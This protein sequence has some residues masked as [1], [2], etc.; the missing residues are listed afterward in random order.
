MA[1]QSTHPSKLSRPTHPRWI[2]LAALFAFGGGFAGAVEE[3][4]SLLTI[5]VDD[6]R[7]LAALAGELEKRFPI[8]VT[9]EEGPWAAA[10]DVED[11]T[12]A[13]IESNGPG[14]PAPVI[15]I[16]G[17]RKAAVSFEYTLDPAED[18]PT[19]YADLLS[20]LVAQYN[21]SGAPGTFRFEGGDLDVDQGDLT[22]P[23]S[24]AVEAAVT[25]TAESP[26]LDEHRISTGATVTQT[27]LREDPDRA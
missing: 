21:S 25:V 24:A 4:P 17:P 19:G 15:P 7:P 11:L 6:H 9:Y 22:K 1:K 12:R 18:K 10:A 14:R 20:A 5:R 3:T 8:V 2:T 16:I 23:P 13:I 26:L 27:E